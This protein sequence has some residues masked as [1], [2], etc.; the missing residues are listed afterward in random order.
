MSY[1]QRND[2][3]TAFGLPDNPALKLIL[4]NIVK[5][6]FQATSC[7]QPYQHNNCNAD[8]PTG[9]LDKATQTQSNR[10]PES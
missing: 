3:T 6:Y 9:G 5:S 2:S 8:N 4:R 1:S 10:Q 7:S